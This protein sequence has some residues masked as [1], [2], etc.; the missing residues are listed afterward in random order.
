MPLIELTREE[1]YERV[2]TI[3]AVE[4]AVELGI[5]D[6]GLGKICRRMGIPKPP[7]GYWRRVETG[8]EVSHV[9]LP[10]AKPGE[11]RSVSFP[12]KQPEG[13]PGPHFQLTNE[14]V[15]A[16]IEAERTE[17]PR[18]SVAGTLEELHPLVRRTQTAY[19]KARPGNYGYLVPKTPGQYLNL[20]ISH[21]SL[22][23]ALRIIDAL[24]KA[25]QARR[26]VNKAGEVIVDGEVISLGI[27]EK[28]SRSDN[29]EP[30]KPGKY[31]WDRP[32]RWIY[33]PTGKLTLW[34]EAT[35]AGKRELQDKANRPLESQ[36]NDAIVK[37][38]ILA[39][40]NKFERQLREE[41]ERRQQEEARRR[42]IEERRRRQEVARRQALE[43]QATIWAQ[44]ETVRAFVRACEQRL[45]A[46]LG[47]IDPSSPEAAW[48]AWAYAHADR[49]D[50]TNG[51]Y[52][53]TAVQQLARK[54]EES[55]PFSDYYPGTD[56]GHL[57]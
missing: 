7:P 31:V 12:G 40:E 27:V 18:I 26:L 54:D 57:R 29:P 43:Q 53:P 21:E 17:A 46:R 35:P 30:K 15:M 5:S 33:T 4:L 37:M 55:E 11:P 50:P 9:A 8:K 34:L 23:R 20:R 39:E 48:L 32:S 2:W 47:A 51:T 16:R 38:L 25:G 44:A 28:F 56:M 6:V 42:Q 14:G 49:L 36:L 24:L 41:A 3:P 1:L 19:N 52:L 22:D 10:K 13:A 45:I